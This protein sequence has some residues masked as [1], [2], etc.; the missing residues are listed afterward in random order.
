MFLDANERRT[1]FLEQVVAELGLAARVTVVR[2]RAE[3]AGR[4]SELRGAFDLV[5]ARSFGPAPV[6]AECGAPF[7]RVEGTL[8]VSEPPADATQ[9]RW[10]PEGLTRLGLVDRGQRGN[11]RVLEQVSPLSDEFPRGTGRPGKRPLW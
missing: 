1:A 8:L 9:G 5:V 2:G 10:A 6:T 11:V 3:A 7:L 4:R